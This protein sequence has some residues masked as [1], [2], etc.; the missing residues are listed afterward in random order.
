MP[1]QLFGAAKSE[2]KNAVVCT[3]FIHPSHDALAPTQ[4][5][6]T[7]GRAIGDRKF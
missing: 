6:A 4:L 7:R 3:R 1:V 2:G 5:L